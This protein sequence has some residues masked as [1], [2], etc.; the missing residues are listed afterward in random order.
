MWFKNLQVFQLTEPFKLNAEQLEDYLVND[1]TRPCGQLEMSTF[2]WT[3]PLGAQHAALTHH[4]NGCIMLA[5]KHQDK[6]LPST[7]V[8]DQVLEQIMQIERE[9]ARK[10]SARER[11]G[12]MDEMMIKLMPKALV[13]SSTTF[14][15]IDLRNQWIVVDAASRPKA[16]EFTILLRKSLGS[17]RLAPVTVKR[18]VPQVLTEWMVHDDYPSDFTIDDQCEL[19]DPDMEK[20]IVRVMNQNLLSQEVLNHI[21]A[22]KQVIKLALTWADRVSFVIDQEFAIKR[23]KFLDLVQEQ[24][25]DLYPDSPEEQFDANFTI[26]NAEF[27]ELLPRLFECFGGIAVEKQAEAVVEEEEV[28]L[29]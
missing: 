9:Q 23:I 11:R 7:V 22:G 3:A 12:M 18:A 28:A 25:S 21:T 24:A 19:R 5:A 15:Y 4:A 20:N 10:V 14:G 6:L 1:A 26:F 17:L 13:K 8:R 16:E 27:A 29:A 2:G